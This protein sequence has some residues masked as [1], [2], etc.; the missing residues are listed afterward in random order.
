M[1]EIKQNSKYPNEA[2]PDEVKNSRA[3]GRSVGAYID[4][5]WLGADNRFAKR[6]AKIRELRT[7]MKGTINLN[8]MYDI[9]GIDKDS[10][11]IALDW[12]PPRTIARYINDVVDSGVGNIGDVNVKGVDPVSNMNRKVYTETMRMAMLTAQ[13]TQDFAGATGVDISPGVPVPQS[14][15]ELQ[16]HMQLDY[17]TLSEIAG[18]AAIKGWW[19][20]NDAE[21][22]YY[23]V[24][25]DMALCGEGGFRVRRSGGKIDIEKATPE[26]VIKSY[27]T[28]HARDGRGTLYYGI[29]RAMSIGDLKHFTSSRG[30]SLTDEDIQKIVSTSKNNLQLYGYSDDIERNRSK[31][32]DDNL[33]AFVIDFCYKTTNELVYKKK[34]NKYGGYKMIQKE[35]SFKKVNETDA[36]DVV[37]GEYDIWYEGLYIPG[38][39]EV[40]GYRKIENQPRKQ[41]NLKQPVPPIVYYE[42]STE[43]IGS[44]ILPYAKQI[45]VNHIKIQQLIAKMRPDGY[46]IDV[47]ALSD[48]DLLDGKH[49]TVDDI[50]I[51]FEQEGNLIFD[52]DNLAGRMD[53]SKPILDMPAPQSNKLQELINTYLFWIKMIQADTG[54]TEA[55]SAV[56]PDPK[57]LVGVQKMQL[58][59]S[60]Q[61]TQ[62]IE[63]GMLNLRRRTADAILMHSQ[64]MSRHKIFNK[65][66]INAIGAYHADALTELVKLGNYEYQ[67]RVE[68]A[69]S[70]EEEEN[71]NTELQLAIKAGSITVDDLYDIR[72][73]KDVNLS[74]V[75]LKVKSAQR[76]KLMMAMNQQNAMAEQQK[77]QGQQQMKLSEI[78]AKTQSQMLIDRNK[79]MLEVQAELEK[80]KNRALIR[81]QYGNPDFQEKVALKDIDQQNQIE[82][83]NTQ[84]GHMDKR[85]SRTKSQE[86]ELIDQR[87]KN[88]PPKDFENENLTELLQ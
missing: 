41:S 35:S 50:L 64:M 7:H 38:M 30:E 62:H 10:S 70:S 82:R 6:R 24:K 88:L 52:G 8:D 58:A 73:I 44:R 21:E 53:G 27:D 59:A 60:L 32:D 2:V 9:M 63:R 20:I 40:Y 75:M 74:R 77:I 29:V 18:K 79:I 67:V 13:F 81:K 23:Q 83:I 34:Y 3:Y 26:N 4:R 87:D 65:Q 22:I 69:M 17:H 51:K 39:G 1:K 45:Y 5:Q 86:S 56:N 57:A 28:Q 47:S 42:L 72:R 54:I 15:D 31:Y 80:E 85:S 36:F 37:R 66:L 12:T 71:F 84:Q 14:E 33:V 11:N 46:A 76:A 43:S 61:S 16:L 48:I 49:Y 19:D 55:R 68:V 25:E 78:Q